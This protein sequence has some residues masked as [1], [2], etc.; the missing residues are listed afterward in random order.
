M[1][2]ANTPLPLKV[3]QSLAVKYPL[4]DV[5]AA[6]ILIAGVA[7]PLDTTGAVPVTDVTG[8]VPLDAAV[9][10]PLP[11]TVK[12]AFV[13]EPTLVFTVANVPVAVTFAEPSKLGLVYAKSPVTAIVLP[14]V[15]VAADPV[16]F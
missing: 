15:S 12:L 16:V 9:I 13:N 7:P 2:F 10:N 14:V 8:A 1:L 6:A 11:L 4:T 5:V 3:V